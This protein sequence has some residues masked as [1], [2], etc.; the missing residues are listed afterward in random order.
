VLQMWVRCAEPGAGCDHDEGGP[1]DGCRFDRRLR[2]LKAC[3]FQ[4]GVEW[5]S[6][7]P[8]MIAWMESGDRTDAINGAVEAWRTATRRH[9]NL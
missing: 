5:N 6:A 8:K 7:L 2:R 9:L 4:K 3:L 1:S